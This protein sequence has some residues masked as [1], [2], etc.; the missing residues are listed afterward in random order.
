MV[1]YIFYYIKILHILSSLIKKKLKTLSEGKKD[2]AK[3]VCKTVTVSNMNIMARK[4][5]NLRTLY[6]HVVLNSVICPQILHDIVLY[7]RHLLL[8]KFFPKCYF[9]K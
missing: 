8:V 6:V 5:T 7:A 3:S 9:L 4:T 1:I 2:I